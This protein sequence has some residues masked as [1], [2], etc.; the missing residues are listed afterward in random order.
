MR[1][2]ASLAGLLLAAPALAAPDCRVLLDNMDTLIGEYYVAGEQ[3]I[4][5]DD[6]PVALD[7]AR[8]LALKGDAEATVTM[9][10]VAAA[11]RGRKAP[12]TVA[13]IRQ[14]CTFSTKNQHPLHAVSCA[15]FNALNPIGER[16]VKR[17]AAMAAVA[18]FDEI[19][20]AGTVPER[21]QAHI[22]A[23]KTCLPEN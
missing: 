16:E 8:K 22:E 18:R 13:M 23:L 3:A 14:V 4:E 21:Y 2:W 1:W 20:K 11:L 9:I 10:G 7:K 15:Y 12:P 5:K 6:P 19:A 17:Q